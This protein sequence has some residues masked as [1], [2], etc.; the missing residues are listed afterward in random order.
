MKEIA[1]RELRECGK[2]ESRK[3]NGREREKKRRRERKR[4]LKEKTEKQ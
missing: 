2:P 3:E 4:Y 1:Y